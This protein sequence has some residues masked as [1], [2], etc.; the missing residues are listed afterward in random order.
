MSALVWTSNFSSGSNTAK[1][2]ACDWTGNRHDSGA[3]GYGKAKAE[4]DAH[5]A[6]HHAEPASEE[7]AP[8]FRPGQMVAAKNGR[9]GV[10]MVAM[11]L[12][13]FGGQPRR[14]V[15][16]NGAVH[17]A[18]RGL[19]GRHPVAKIDRYYKLVD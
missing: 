5:D 2:K 6:E 11:I 12:P 17:V 1:C 18:K 9:G 16:D 14:Y 10:Y 8:A 15:L 7:E 13:A 19:S 3:Y 4:A